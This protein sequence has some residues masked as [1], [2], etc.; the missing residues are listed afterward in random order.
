MNASE[1]VTAVAAVIAALGGGSGGLYA[2]RISADRRKIGADAA[3]VLSGTAV[4][5]LDPMR[6]EI[7][8]LT[9]RVRDLETQVGTLNG[10]LQHANNLLAEH[11]LTS[12]SPPAPLF[13]LD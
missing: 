4:S 5:L 12:G 7:D 13:P 3:Q 6:A 2:F 8:R 11:G 10:Q 1:I 9:T